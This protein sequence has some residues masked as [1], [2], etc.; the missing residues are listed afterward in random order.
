MVFFSSWT[1]KSQVAVAF[2]VT[3]LT[4][5]LAVRFR[6]SK[7]PRSLK[8]IAPAVAFPRRSDSNK[9][10]IAQLIVRR[11][12]SEKQRIYAVDANGS[13]T[14]D[15]FF[16][17]SFFLGKVLRRLCGDDGNHV[18]VMMD[19]CIEYLQIYAACALWDLVICPINVGLSVNEQ[20]RV[21]TNVN[22]T[23]LIT[24]DVEPQAWDIIIVQ[25]SDLTAAFC[26]EANNREVDPY[27]LA[28]ERWDHWSKS[29]ARPWMIL[30]TSGTSTGTPKGVVRSQDSSVGGFEVHNRVL[31]F[32]K[33][34]V[35]L[36]SWPLHSISSAYFAFNYLDAGMKIVMQKG[37]APE[38]FAATLAEHTVHFMT[39]PTH[40]AL[41]LELPRTVTKL[42]VSG[43]LTSV[44]PLRKKFPWVRLFDGYG[45]TE[46]GLICISD[47]KQMNLYPAFPDCVRLA[48][49]PN[50]E[51]EILAKTPM[52]FTEYWRN[53]AKT[54]ESFVD[55][56][57]L[58]ADLGEWYGKYLR[59]LGRKDD[60]LT[61]PS[62]QK[63]FPAELE[64]VL[65]PCVVL[66]VPSNA[67]AQKLVCV[68]DQGAEPD[69]RSRSYD[70]GPMRRPH[71]YVKVDV[72]PRT[73]TGKVIRIR[74]RERYLGQK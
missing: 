31:G 46:A 42:F 45:S 19:N 72:L 5:L 8:D 36:M 50:G 39:L 29:G 66:G 44:D 74:V 11:A 40:T 4:I 2:T 65:G 25:R 37:I 10:T 24:D 41:Q 33:D 17:R 57:F 13:I 27:D 34:T 62:G 15:D 63:I 3:S 48:R 49:L 23:L 14:Y 67:D 38:A 21:L 20:K 47:N 30:S 32:T 1:T 54:T 18:A 70:L 53:S 58:T 43:T 69:F 68:F 61:L 56:Y 22:A 73:A 60:L 7:W 35:A 28:I 51:H 64:N 59:V 55:G 6:G 71:E 12:L 52:M 9:E 26:A 16:R